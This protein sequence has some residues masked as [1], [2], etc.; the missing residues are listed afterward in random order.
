M[1]RFPLKLA[2]CV[3][4]IAQSTTIWSKGQTI[5]IE[6]DGDGLS[7]PVVIT[8]PDILNR[9]N[10]WNGPGVSVSGPDGVQYP[11]AH[12]DP[13]RTAGRFVDWPSGPVSEK[14]AGLQCLEVTFHVGVPRDPN[15]S[16]AYVVAYE[17]DPAASSGYIYLPRWT[18]DLISHGV[19]GN[20]FHAS[21]Q[22]SDVI[23]PLI[24]E[25]TAHSSSSVGPRKLSCI[26]GYS[27]LAVDGTIADIRLP[28]K[29]NRQ[30]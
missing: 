16:R 25:Q 27:S 7:A 24:A 6:I 19:E 5:R 20:W 8:D 12:L 15:R 29:R 17:V 9:F 3:L 30:H 26:A 23:A 14:R 13:S 21:E 2:F 11:P 10:I 18:N 28:N 4:L 1:K 22:W